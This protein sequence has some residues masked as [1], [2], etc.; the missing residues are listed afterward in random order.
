MISRIIPVVTLLT[1]LGI[2]VVGFFILTKKESRNNTPRPAPSPA[3]LPLKSIGWIPYWDQEKAFAT[4]QTNASSFDFISVFWYGLSKEGEVIKYEGVVEDR[5]IIK[6]AKENQIKVMALFA[7]LIEEEGDVW[8]AERVNKVISD[9]QKRKVHTQEILTK[10]DEF[11]FDGVDIDYEALKKPQRNDYTQFIKELAD[12]LHKQDKLIGISIHPK[13]SEDNPAEYNGSQAQDWQ[14][15]AKVVDHM[16]FMTYGEY[17]DKSK[18]GPIASLPWVRNVINYALSIGVPRKKIFMGIPLYGLKWQ[19][20]NGAFEPAQSETEELL[21]D[22]IY[23]LINNSSGEVKWDSKSHASY[24]EYQT[25]GISNII[26]FED[27]RSVEDKIKFANKTGL[28]GV[29]F[30]RLGGEDPQ[31]WTTLHNSP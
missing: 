20:I 2:L 5:E 18:V 8:D 9:P 11:D 25:L 4:V 14:N 21:Y 10:V 26:W 3:P 13:T 29:G 17:W 12:A 22:D 7:N 15:L 1:V 28:G 30:W 23:Y 16:Y 27:S 24:F 6:F 31:V 19:K